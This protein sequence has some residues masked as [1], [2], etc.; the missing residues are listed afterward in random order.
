VGCT[1]IVRSVTTESVVSAKVVTE[2]LSMM[3]CIVGVS[4]SRFQLHHT[5]QCD[6]SLPGI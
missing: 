4:A 1:P 3:G 2:F 6:G 5:T